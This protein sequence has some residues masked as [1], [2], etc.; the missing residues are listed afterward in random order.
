MAGLR[1]LGRRRAA[2]AAA[3]AVLAL[4]GA[5]LAATLIGAPAASAEGPNDHDLPVLPDLP[6][7]SMRGTGELHADGIHLVHSGGTEG[8]ITAHDRLLVNDDD[9]RFEIRAHLI[10]GDGADPTLHVHEVGS[11]VIYSYDLLVSCPHADVCRL[12][13]DVYVEFESGGEWEVALEYGSGKVHEWQLEVYREG[14]MLGNLDLPPFPA[15]PALAMRGDGSLLADGIHMVP[16]RVSEQA[17]TNEEGELIVGD[18]DGEFEVRAY[19]VAP[20]GSEATLHVYDADDHQLRY[21]YDMIV[22]CPTQ[23]LCRVATDLVLHLGGGGTWN[24]DLEHIEGVI[25]DWQLEVYRTP[26]ASLPT[27]GTGGLLETERA[28]S[29]AIAGMLAGSAAIVVATGLL[30]ARVRRRAN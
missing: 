14:A 21:E 3:L 15:P 17:A 5:A 19:F 4:V 10:G 25:Q 26:L 29:A 2:A 11:E 7:L 27:T 18:D 22:A 8:Y 12:V 9:G 1:F 13:S 20:D 23:P 16:L 28:G 6:V 24:V 30:A